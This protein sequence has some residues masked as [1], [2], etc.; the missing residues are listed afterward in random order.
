MSR[1][2]VG[3][4][5]YGMGNHTSV[6]NCLKSLEYRCKIS[7]EKTVLSKSDVILIPGVGAFPTAKAELQK[8]GLV[9]FLQ[10]EAKNHKPIIGICL[11]MQL[12][13][14]ASYEFG[15]TSGLSIIPGEIVPI[16]EPKWHIGWNTL[17]IAQEDSI[18]RESDGESF[19]FNHS[20]IYR[21][22]REYQIG[23]TDTKKSFPAIIRRGKTVG[24]QFHPEKSQDSGSKLMKRLIEGLCNA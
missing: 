19:Y 2:Q 11:G 8:R 22:P 21:G 12:L 18:F 13:A 15:Y 24:L 20:F 9:E 4:V 23:L 1:I 14:E 7:Y 5:D 16:N 10:H 17:E 6:F 3:L